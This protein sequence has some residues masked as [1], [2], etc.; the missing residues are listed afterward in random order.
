MIELPD[1]NDALCFN[2]NDNPG[3]IF[4]LVRDQTSG[5][6]QMTPRASEPF[7]ITIVSCHTSA[8][9]LVNGQIIGDKKIPTD[10]HINTYFCRFGIVHQKLGVRLQVS[11]H[12]ITVFQNG[13]QV[14]LV[15]SETASLKGTK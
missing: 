6:F 1:R 9:I 13:K 5:Q 11:T 4:N 14:K 7:M 2:V 12:D 3:T 10:G 15:W 8:G